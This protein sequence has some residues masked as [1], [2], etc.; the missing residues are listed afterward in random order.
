MTAQR[1]LGVDPLSVQLGVFWDRFGHIEPYDTYASLMNVWRIFTP[2]DIQGGSH[3]GQPDGP[4]FG[5][6]LKVSRSSVVRLILRHG[7]G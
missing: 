2:S 6:G 3:D 1:F 4:V 7:S 5:Y